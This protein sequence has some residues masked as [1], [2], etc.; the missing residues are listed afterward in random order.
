MADLTGRVEA[1]PEIIVELAGSG[2]P[3]PPGDS[4]Y[5][6]SNGNWW[7]GETDTGAPVSGGTELEPITNTEM[8][9]MLK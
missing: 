2:P 5:I 7:V 8:E 3:G 1:P 9:D 4:P 6:G